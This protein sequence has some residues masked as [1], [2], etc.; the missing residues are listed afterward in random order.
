MTSRRNE[1]NRLTEADLEAQAATPLPDRNVMQTLSTPLLDADVNLDLALDLAAPVD[2]A[3]AANANV[4]LAVD[5]AVSAS[6]ASPDS[7]STAVADQ[8][9]IINQTMEGD[10]TAVANQ[11]S[12]I[13]QGDTTPPTDTTEGP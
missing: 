8:G 5:A 11:T 1:L 3:V 10:A 7:T 13:E 6:V 12:T 2:A 4:G 9:V